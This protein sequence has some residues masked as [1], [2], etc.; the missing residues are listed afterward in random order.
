MF[1]VKDQSLWS[2]SEIPLE[3]EKSVTAETPAQKTSAS[4]A[5]APQTFLKPTIFLYDL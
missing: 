2:Q 4:E 5:A 1:A 3:G